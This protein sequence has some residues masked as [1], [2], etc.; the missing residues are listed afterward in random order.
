MTNAIDKQHLI[1]LLR[2]SLEFAAPNRTDSCQVLKGRSG[3]RG[4]ML[5]LTDVDGASVIAKAWKAR[6]LTERMKSLF[7]WSMAQHEWQAHRYMEQAGLTVPKLLHFL[8]LR[9]QGGGCFEVIVVEDLG[10]TRNGL[11]YLKDLLAAGDDAGIRRFEE[12]VISMTRDLVDAGLVDVDHQLRNIV[13]NGTERPIRIDFECARRFTRG[14]P[15]APDY[16]RMIGRLVVSHAY[17]C[18]PELTRTRCFARRLAQHLNPPR[19][20]LEGAEA[21]IA[22]ALARQ[23]ERIGIDSPLALDW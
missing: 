7:G 16:G 2:A 5:R 6:N 20:V 23:R 22:H 17:A 12:R 4:L 11:V 18:Q 10:P 3:D 13:V 14:F 8:R 15:P 1:S 19:T 21:Q 9:S